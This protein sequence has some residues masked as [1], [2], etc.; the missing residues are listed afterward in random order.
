MTVIASLALAGC[1]PKPPPPTAEPPPTPRKVEPPRATPGQDGWPTTLYYPRL[2]IPM[3]RLRR[4]ATTGSADGIDFSAPDLVVAH[5]PLVTGPTAHGAA[6]GTEVFWVQA[7]GVFFL[8]SD[9]QGQHKD[10]YLGPFPGD[11]R[12]VLAPPYPPGPPADRQRSAPLREE[13]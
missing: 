13:G 8:R 4:Q 12:Q 6:G 3:E 10:G 11:P 1:E 7:R 5:Y 9:C 2:G